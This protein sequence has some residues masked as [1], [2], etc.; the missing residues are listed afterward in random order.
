LRVP[1]LDNRL[2]KGTKRAVGV[3]S[4]FFFLQA[5][6]QKEVTQRHALRLFLF[7]MPRSHLSTLRG[8]QAAAA[9]RSTPSSTFALRLASCDKAPQPCSVEITQF[10]TLNF[11][12]T[13]SIARVSLHSF[14]CAAFTRQL[15]LR[16]FEHLYFLAVTKAAVAAVWTD[17]CRCTMCGFGTT[18]SVRCSK[19]GAR[20]GRIGKRLLEC[21]GWLVCRP[22][23]VP[24]VAVFLSQSLHF[25]SANLRFV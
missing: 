22:H 13:A 17:E 2:C 14:N 12:C 20:G 11:G 4:L 9:Q 23:A 25:S 24:I 18:T 21:S 3:R 19:V 16:S 7:A 15:L 6:R 8:V 1:N 10:L 5:W